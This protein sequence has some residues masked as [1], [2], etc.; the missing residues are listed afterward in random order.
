MGDLD[1]VRI[2]IARANEHL[3]E[4]KRR[5]DDWRVSKPY[6]IIV[7]IEP[8]TRDQLWKVGEEPARP[9]D[10]PV[11]GD[12]LFNL[13][14]A[15]DHLA[16]QLVLKANLRKPST[17]TEFPIFNDLDVWKSDSPRKMAGMNDLMKD[18]I[19][20]LQP[21]FTPYIYRAEALWG[22][23][24]YGNTDKHRTL[25]VIPVST[26]DMLWEPGGNPRYIH[27]GPVQKETVL[28]R[29]AEGEYQSNFR[30]MPSVAFNDPPSAGEDVY[31][32]LGFMEH[33]V[34]GIVDDFE[35]A[36]FK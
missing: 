28:A 7:E 5:L 17:R 33:T 8:D 14:S 24:E 18:R 13:R 20:A 27:K 29:F 31:Y 1:G 16:W 36:F 2:K 11:V 34:V 35:T 19:K 12:I 10:L 32:K 4:L 21:C 9:P 6:P 22:L 15:L 30:A 3:K 26:Q 23:Q 25:L